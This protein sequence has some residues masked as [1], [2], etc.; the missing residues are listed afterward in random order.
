M[1]DKMSDDR[2]NR[3]DRMPSRVRREPTVRRP[4]NQLIMRIEE[5][6]WYWWYLGR[7][8][9]GDTLVIGFVVVSEEARVRRQFAGYRALNWQRI[10]IIIIIFYLPKALEC[11]RKWHSSSMGVRSQAEAKHKILPQGL[12]NKAVLF[13]KKNEF[14]EVEIEWQAARRSQCS[15]QEN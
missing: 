6:V 5:L 15:M 10:I 4:A 9:K 2:L 14:E 11:I 3:F 7:G 1:H 8:S 13:L 12:F